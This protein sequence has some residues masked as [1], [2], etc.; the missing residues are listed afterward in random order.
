MSMRVLLALAPLFAAMSLAPA[1]ASADTLPKPCVVNQKDY[2]DEY[3]YSYRLTRGCT[4][5]VAGAT[6][7][8]GD[9]EL[10]GGLGGQAFT[11][12]QVETARLFVTCGADSV[13]DFWVSYQHD[14]VGCRAARD[15]EP[16]AEAYCRETTSRSSP[17][18]EECV[19]GPVTIGCDWIGV[20]RLDPR[21]PHS[22]YVR[23]G[24]AIDP[25]FECSFDRGDP[26]G[27]LQACASGARA[28]HRSRS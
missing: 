8:C 7:F 21:V 15:G 5:H 27:S 22:C 9:Q 19:V 24:P 14:G 2:Q 4:L 10:I 25:V 20:L 11:G 18:V 26:A 6:I 12:C 13:S 1:A 23:I 17:P 3:G 16:L 28:R